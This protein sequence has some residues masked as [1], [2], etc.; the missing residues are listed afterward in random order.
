MICARI[1]AAEAA[2]AAAI[3]AQD[4]GGTIVARVPAADGSAPSVVAAGSDFIT[5]AAVTTNADDWLLLPAP[6]AGMPIIRGWSVV[7]HE[8][9]TV[10]ASG[11]TINGVDADGTPNEVAIPATTLWH[12]EAIS[13][14]AWIIKAWDELGAP[15]AALVPHA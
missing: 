13:S 4:V 15:I 8:I 10:A 14:T 5:V 12:A 7:A 1:D 2:L 6:V 11:Q 3:G 9:R